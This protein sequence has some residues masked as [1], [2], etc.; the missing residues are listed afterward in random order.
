M[1]K[2]QH[3]AATKINFKSRMA[4]D[5]RRSYRRERG[6]PELAYGRRQCFDRLVIR[7]VETLDARRRDGSWATL[8]IQSRFRA[9]ACFRFLGNFVPTLPGGQ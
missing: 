1:T 5:E 8:G 4:S 6:L 2:R 3:D 7:Q 9:P